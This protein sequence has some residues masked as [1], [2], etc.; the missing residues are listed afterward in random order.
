[1]KK[2]SKKAAKRASK[3]SAS[4]KGKKKMSKK[5]SAKKI[6][7]RTLYTYVEP[8]NRQFAI[9]MAK[10]LGI[11]GGYSGYINNLLSERRRRI[12][13]AKAA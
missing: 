5:T 8:R 12:E 13:Q 1:M 10:R 3:P 9:R 4:S 11:E 7:T 2:K 6:L